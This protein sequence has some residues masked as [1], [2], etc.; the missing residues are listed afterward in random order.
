MDNNIRRRIGQEQ[1]NQET[2]IQNKGN[3]NDFLPIKKTRSEQIEDIVQ[4]AATLEQ[5]LKAKIIKYGDNIGHNRKEVPTRMRLEHA[6]MRSIN[7]PYSVAWK[8]PAVVGTLAGA[9]MPL[10]VRALGYRT[11]LEK[12]AAG[13]GY[14]NVTGVSQAL[15]IKGV[16]RLGGPLA[17]E[18]FGIAAAGA[19]VGGTIGTAINYR[20]ITFRNLPPELKDDLLAKDIDDL[21]S[22]LF[23]E[24]KDIDKEKVRHMVFGYILKVEAKK[25]GRS[26]GFTVDRELSIL[27]RISRNGNKETRILASKIR[28]LA[29]AHQESFSSIDERRNGILELLDLYGR[30]WGSSEQGEPVDYPIR[31]SSGDYQSFAEMLSN[32]YEKTLMNAAPEPLED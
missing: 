32:I 2:Y 21:S 28:E 22:K 27:S 17:V 6:L 1:V 25:S 4:S 14:L 31:L 13:V 5:L 7:A 3:K 30:G 24:F 8:D 16:T 23:E 19:L 10:P 18:A 12:I 15:G 20:N 26:L 29:E 9:W 11:P